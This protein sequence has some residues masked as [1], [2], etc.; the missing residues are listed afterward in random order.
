MH[1]VTFSSGNGSMELPRSQKVIQSEAD[2][3][4]ER[5]PV[6]SGGR[7]AP[8]SLRW[9]LYYD[10]NCS[11]LPAF[12][13]RGDPYPIRHATLPLPTWHLDTLFRRRI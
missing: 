12:I 10:G 6:D 3:L 11:S 7:E 9:S 1:S 4:D 2:D 13:K 8:E 5:D